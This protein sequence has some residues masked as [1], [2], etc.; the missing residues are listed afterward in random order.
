MRR[1]T[2]IMAAGAT[3]LLA[4]SAA[5]AQDA[6][7][8]VSVNDVVGAALLVATVVLLLLAM[9]LERVARG[10]AI[11]DNISYV[12]VACVCLGASSLA[13][14]SDRFATEGA[15]RAQLALSA[16]ALTLVGIILLC[17][18]FFRVR[19]ALQRF[20]SVTMAGEEAL[21]RA[22]AG[23]APPDAGARSEQSTTGTAGGDDDA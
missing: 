10:S 19:A 20:L 5:Y 17:V 3:A 18:Y 23:E 11:A 6:A 9:G 8:A 22:Q 12:V 13:A 2:L 7:G 14:W 4:P 1:A 15:T 16:D 21:A